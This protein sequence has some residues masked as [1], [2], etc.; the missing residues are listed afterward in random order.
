MLHPKIVNIERDTDTAYITY[1]AE[2]ILNV[3]WA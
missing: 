2:I 1:T 3:L